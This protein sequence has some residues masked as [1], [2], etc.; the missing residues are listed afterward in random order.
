MM[1]E[2]Q[3]EDCVSWLWSCS[4]LSLVYTW[5]SDDASHG[6]VSYGPVYSNAVWQSLVQC[7][8]TNL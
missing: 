7:S 1:D 6:L 8:Y 5:W 4:L 3:K 2:V